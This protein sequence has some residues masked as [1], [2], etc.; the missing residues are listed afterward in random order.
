MSYL[1][2]KDIAKELQ[3]SLRTA[4]RMVA[5]GLPVIHVH[6]RIYRVYKDALNQFLRER[7]HIESLPNLNWR[8][9]YISEY[10]AGERE[11]LA[12][13]NKGRQKIKENL[14][15]GSQCS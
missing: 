4:S 3:V 15:K 11:L 12:L 8:C 7:T 14:N 1:T 9:G 10:S 13:R 6:G 5:D 2:F